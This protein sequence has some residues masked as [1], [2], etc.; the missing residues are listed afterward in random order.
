M[1]NDLSY[2]NIYGIS[3]QINNL[4][5]YLI[6]II[7]KNNYILLELRK[8]YNTISKINNSDIEKQKVSKRKWIWQKITFMIYSYEY[9]LNNY[10]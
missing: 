2:K 8:K 9:L 1:L 7:L 3:L 6:Y 10:L 5:L 4:D